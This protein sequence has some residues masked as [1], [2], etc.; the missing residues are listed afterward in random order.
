M[1]VPKNSFTAT[2]PENKAKLTNGLRNGNPNWPGRGGNPDRKNT[3][4]AAL[5]RKK[6]FSDF[7]HEFYTANPERLK[8]LVKKADEYAMKGHA[9][10]LELII[11]RLEGPVKISEAPTTFNFNFLSDGDRQRAIDSVRRIAGMDAKTIT[12]P[13]LPEE[14]ECQTTSYSSETPDLKPPT[15]E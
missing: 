7:L 11:D 1:T 6:L 4:R 12:L 2:S 5:E 3:G 9:R 15:T 10:F 8:K 14:S 13:Q